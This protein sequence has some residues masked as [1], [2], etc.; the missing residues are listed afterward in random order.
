M[1]FDSHRHHLV[2]GI[3]K[4]RE[5]DRAEEKSTF[6]GWKHQTQK[7]AETEKGKDGELDQLNLQTEPEWYGSFFFRI[8][9]R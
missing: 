2:F 8:T 6:W 3:F 9:L 1:S 4:F 7:L 5:P